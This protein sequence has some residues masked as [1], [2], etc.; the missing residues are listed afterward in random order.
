MENG[1]FVFLSPRWGLKSNVR[2][3]S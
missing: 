2:W 3:L 1:R